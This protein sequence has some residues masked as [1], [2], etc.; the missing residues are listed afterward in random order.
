MTFT[1]NNTQ[2]IS[3]LSRVCVG[4][5]SYV[6]GKNMRVCHAFTA[7]DE[8]FCLHST[9]IARRSLMSVSDFLRKKTTNVQETCKTTDGSGRLYLPLLPPQLI[10]PFSLLWLVP[11]S[12]WP[13]IC[14]EFQFQLCHSRSDR[15]LSS[16]GRCR[17]KRRF[18][19]QGFI[20]PCYA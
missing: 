12:R 10:L 2:Y 11:F 4:D 17:S 19:M 14:R 6:R 9:S 1:E 18:G 7:H 15:T 13:P 16:V 5:V 20:R 3:H 8:V